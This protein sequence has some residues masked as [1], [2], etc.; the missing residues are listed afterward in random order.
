ESGVEMYLVPVM[1][2]YRAEIL[3][4]GKFAPYVGVGA[5]A[6]RVNVEQS[7][8]G[9]SRADKDTTFAAQAFAGVTYK[10]TEKVSLH[11]GARYIWIGEIQLFASSPF[12]LGDD[13]SLEAGISFKF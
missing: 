5:G 6:A 7:F 10:A 8:G 12:E 2:N 3:S 13:V 1:L 9:P 4:T 11:L